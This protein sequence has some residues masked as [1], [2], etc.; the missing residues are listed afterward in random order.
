VNAPP[1]TAVDSRRATLHYLPGLDG[2]R[3]ISVLAVLVYHQY[4]VGGHEHGWMAGGFLGVE[5]FFVVSGYLIT[6]LLLA[7]R[8]QTG[9]ISLRHFWQRRARRLLP[10]LYVLL[11]VVVAYALLFL[12]DAISNLKSD[13]IAALTYTSNWWQIIANR[14]YFLEAGRPSLLKQLW[15]LAIEEQFY[16]FWPVLL[17]VGLRKIGRRR[18]LVLT[19]AAALASAIEMAVLAH[20]SFDRAYYGTDTRLSG[21]LLGSAFAFAFAPYRIRGVP[22]RGARVALD[23]S[24]LVGLLVLFWSFR[25][26][27]D[28]NPAVFRGGFLIVDIATLL[29]IAAAVHPRSDTG[30]ILGWKPLRWVGVR[31]YS[32][33]LWH[34]PIFCVTRP[35]LDFRYL[36]HLSGW[37]VFVLRFVLSFGAADLSYRFVETPIRGGALGRYMARMRDAH[38]MRRTRLAGRGALV[39]ASLSLVALLLG[40]GLANAQPETEKVFGVDS[41]A[42]HDDRGEKPDA[43]VVNSLLNRATSS[44]TT[45]QP[46]AVGR[47]SPTTRQPTATTK[48]APPARI[49]GP[50]PQAL[51]IGDS[52]MLGARRALAG[53]IPGIAVDAKVSRQFWQ[54][55]DVLTFYRNNHLLPN[56]VIVHLGTNGKFGPGS[57]DSLM[58]AAGF[59]QVFLVN[60]FVPRPWEGDVNAALAAG[61]Q[62]WHNA[63]VLD[64]HGY[65]AKHLDWFAP[66]DFHLSRIGAQA[67]AQFVRAGIS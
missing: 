50:P 65:A 40:A 32:L 58:R 2:I 47:T 54:A 38:G 19:I 37:P 20:G 28:T 33:Y 53:A 5:V 67:Y 15:S 41:S 34:Y 18:F 8:R 52:V 6:S 57:L 46:S 25:H 51:A 17:I 10:A 56:I 43:S 48:P 45:S 44:T 49:A 42:H 39:A 4:A 30:R 12:P 60:A 24:A 26:W 23:L 55:V 13:V 27:N 16:L 11:A 64:W 62:R 31:S 61:A 22:G 35:V 66:D 9:T 63:H 29:V 21:L 3:A 59:R 1:S 7:E 14:S 36:G